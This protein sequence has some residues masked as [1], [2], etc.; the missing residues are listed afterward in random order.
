MEDKIGTR[1]RTINIVRN[2]ANTNPTI[3]IIVS[4]TSGLHIPMK[5]QRLSVWIEKQDP[6]VVYKKPP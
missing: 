6:N 3:S 4:V 2:I 5:R 1:T